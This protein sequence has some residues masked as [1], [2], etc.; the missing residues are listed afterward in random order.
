MGNTSAGNG[1]RVMEMVE[2]GGATITETRA[3]CGYV[4]RTS[5][6]NKNRVCAYDEP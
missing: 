2:H 4:V 1:K 5:P 3:I 6:R